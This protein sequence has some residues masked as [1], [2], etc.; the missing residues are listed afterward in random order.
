MSRVIERKK[1]TI[2][3]VRTP[4]GAERY[5][6]PIGSIIVLDDY[7]N[8][9]DVTGPQA[10]RPGQD[11]PVQPGSERAEAPQEA[12]DSHLRAGLPQGWE[13]GQDHGYDR[14][15]TSEQRQAKHEAAKTAKRQVVADI[16]RRLEHVPDEVLV[17]NAERVVHARLSRGD[18]VMVRR[19]TGN[20]FDS[21]DDPFSRAWDYREVPAGSLEEAGGED[22]LAENGLERVSAEDYLAWNR[23]ESVGRMVALWAATSNGTNPRALTMQAIAE[24][25]FGLSNVMPWDAPLSKDDEQ[26][27]VD[28]RRDLGERYREFLLAQYAATQETFREQGIT[29]VRLF[30]GVR[31]YKSDPP[32]WATPG[33]DRQGIPLRPMSSFTSDRRVAALFA[34]QG[35]DFGNTDGYLMESIVPVERI[36]STPRTG[37]GCLSEAEF[38][39]LAGEGSWDVSRTSKADTER[40]REDVEPDTLLDLAEPDAEPEEESAPPPSAARMTD[41]DGNEVYVDLDPAVPADQP[42]EADVYAPDGALLGRIQ[43]TT[44]DPSV[45]E[46]TALDMDGKPVG[47]PGEIADVLA[48]VRA[49]SWGG[50]DD[51]EAAVSGAA[52]TA[53]SRPD[54]YGPDPVPPAP[55]G[56]A[57]ETTNY[58]GREGDRSHLTRA[59]TG[60]IPTD[61]IATMPGVSG[62]VPGEHR[63]KQGAEW[64]AFVADIRANGIQ[65]P[66]FITIDWDGQPRI[67]EGNHR[68]DAAVEAGLTDVPVEIR[69]FGHAQRQNP[70]EQWTGEWD[71]ADD[72]P[73]ASAPDAAPAP[74]L[75]L[76]RGATYLSDREMLEVIDASDPDAIL[77]F[78]MNLGKDV[79]RPA[80][81]LADPAFTGYPPPEDKPPVPTAGEANAAAS[82]PQWAQKARE[83]VVIPPFPDEATMPYSDDREASF[84]F[85]HDGLREDMETRAK[86]AKRGVAESIAARLSGIPDKALFDASY[87]SWWNEVSRLP[88]DALVVRDENK[89]GPTYVQHRPDWHGD[90]FPTVPAGS[91]EVYKAAREG[92]VASL[93]SRWAATSNDSDEQALALQQAA[94]EVFDLDEDNLHTWPIPPG[95]QAA[96]DA[97]LASR[98]DVYRAFLKA[99]YA[100][101]QERLEEAGLETVVLYRGVRLDERPAWASNLVDPDS[102]E[103]NDDGEFYEVAEPLGVTAIPL[104]PLSSFTTAA[105]TAVMFAETGNTGPT[106]ARHRFVMKAN[107]ARQRILS[108]PRSGFGCLNEQEYVVLGGTPQFEVWHPQD[109]NDPGSDL[110]EEAYGYGDDDDDSMGW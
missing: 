30:R 95:T 21:P 52:P 77:L 19:A 41:A 61:L 94:R 27:M 58:E 40:P 69:Y 45:N 98:G 85:L 100:E 99:Q 42:S 91:P 39:V 110:D 50:G 5:G 72:E 34:E 43:A 59:Q 71:G 66:I 64:D 83:P 17:D 8:V 46:F 106:G 104:R 88:A 16:T 23:A 109:L 105:E 80:A 14:D 57:L 92:A 55:E 48:T 53:A 54:D 22:T 10:T 9:V 25:T 103:P 38:V 74:D 68:R 3:H 89:H 51:P 60:T 11:G 28:V 62:E 2:R 24:E 75:D 65:R 31:A 70:V 12:V 18:T 6:Q 63:N 93:I 44:A 101:T 56:V 97:D 26:A 84:A 81:Y 37:V 13:F 20:E 15:L 67:S 78:D 36:L 86:T 4:E 73:E 7:G 29:D 49:E 87:G 47:E 108:T 33:Y 79:T 82:D 35:S 32:S 96:V 102:D 107:V 90:R 1:Q 76:R